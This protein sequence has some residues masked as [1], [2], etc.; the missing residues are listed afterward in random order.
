[1]GAALPQPALPEPAAGESVG[2][3]GW[4]AATSAKAANPGCISKQRR[5]RMMRKA[6]RTA[7]KEGAKAGV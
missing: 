7:G 3:G 1:M 4:A 5:S 6:G 2:R